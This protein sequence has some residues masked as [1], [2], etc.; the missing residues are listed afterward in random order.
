VARSREGCRGAFVKKQLR[1][2]HASLYSHSIK[3]ESAAEAHPTSW[4]D[5][6]TFVTAPEALPR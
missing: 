6:M 5:R 3:G 4:E 1:Q 2:V